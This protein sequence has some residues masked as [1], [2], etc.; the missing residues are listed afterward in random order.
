MLP[1]RSDRRRPG[2]QHRRDER[3]GRRLALGAGDA[4]GSCRA[5]A[6][7]EVDLADD[8]RPAFVPRARRARVRRRGSVV[9]I[10]A[11]D[12]GRGADQR[13]A[14]RARTRGSTSGPSEQLGRRHAIDLLQLRRSCSAGPSVVDRHLRPGRSQEAASVRRHCA[15]ARARPRD[16]RRTNRES[17]RSS[18]DG[19]HARARL[20]DRAH[21]GTTSVEK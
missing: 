15:R 12:R 7:E 14:R 20:A 5:Q 1:P 2:S 8:G 6:Q 4:D 16:A 19:V 3:R 18:I 13:L 9:G 17:S 21:A 10:A 11:A